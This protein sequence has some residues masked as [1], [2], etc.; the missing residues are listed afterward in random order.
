M[1]DFSFRYLEKEDFPKCASAL[2]EIMHTNMSVIAPSENSYD[3][4]FRC[5]LDTFGKTFCNRAEWE[6]VIIESEEKI[7]GFFAY[8]CKDN[9]FTMQEIQF[10]DSIK[11]KDRIFRKLY[12]FVTDSLPADLTYIE[13]YAH[14]NNEKS[15]AILRR[16]GLKNISTNKNG[17]CYHFKGDYEDYLLWLNGTIRK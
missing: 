16:L 10:A 4:D 6:I 13:A 7:G 5:W 15:I 2:F 3:E 1:T 17:E 12:C 9:T 11:G 14:K 8:S